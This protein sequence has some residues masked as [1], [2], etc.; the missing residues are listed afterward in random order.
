MTLTKAKDRIR[1]LILAQTANIVAEIDAYPDIANVEKWYQSHDQ[2]RKLFDNE[3]NICGLEIRMT[4]K[5]LHNYRFD[6]FNQWSIWSF[7]RYSYN[8]LNS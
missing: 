3:S 4:C 2:L 5:G 6:V 7:N 1:H 8:N